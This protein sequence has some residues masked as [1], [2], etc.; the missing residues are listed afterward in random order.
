MG[1]LAG[2]Q[3]KGMVR[4]S[5]AV[6]A[7]CA[8]SLIGHPL[9]PA[10]MVQAREDAPPPPEPERSADSAALPPVIASSW[11]L[12]APVLPRD[13]LGRRLRLAV[14]E[15]PLPELICRKEERPLLPG[16]ATERTA[17]DPPERLVCSLSTALLSAESVAETGPM[18]THTYIQAAALAHAAVHAM[19]AV[20]TR[21]AIA[22]RKVKN[23]RRIVGLF[24]WMALIA[25]AAG[26]AVTLGDAAAPWLLF[27]GQDP[28]HRGAPDHGAGSVPSNLHRY[29][30]EPDPY[31]AHRIT[32]RRQAVARL[33]AIERIID[34]KAAILLKRAGVPAD[35]QLR[36]YELLARYRLT[37]LHRW[38]GFDEVAPNALHEA[39]YARAARPVPEIH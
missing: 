37:N 17:V 24:S 30:L 13:L 38:P 22:S 33:V 20:Q 19:D 16:G 26:G 21:L 9:L 7:I 2:N 27:Y 32:R 4:V 14:H 39:A 6:L 1:L 29:G 8:P 23:R 12:L 28:H 5:L 3:H 18:E 34:V 31:L 15:A 25:G 35:S 11:R 10:A 36:L